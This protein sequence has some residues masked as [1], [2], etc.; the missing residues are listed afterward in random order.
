MKRGKIVQYDGAKGAGI[1]VVD[2]QQLSFDISQWQ[3]SDAPALNGLVQVVEQDGGVTSI[4][5]VSDGAVLK[6]QTQAVQ[7]QVQEHGKRIYEQVTA[8]YGLPSTVAYGLF[9]ITIYMLSFVSMKVFM[10]SNSLTLSQLVSQLGMTGQS[11]LAGPLFWLALLAPMAPFFVKHK[12]AWLGL[13]APALLV[14]L[15][16]FNLWSEYQSQAET[17][18]KMKSAFGSFGGGDALQA[19]FSNMFSFGIGFYLALAASAYLAYVGITRY[20]AS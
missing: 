5:P 6:E 11:S 20:R 17:M 19:S 15:V 3:G 13:A 9:V 10:A 8:T 16:G 14:V 18:N 2:G 1:A 7:Q 4:S 12:A